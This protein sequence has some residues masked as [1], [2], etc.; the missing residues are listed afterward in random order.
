MDASVLR[1]SVNKPCYRTVIGGAMVSIDHFRK[2]LLAQLARA[3]IGGRIDILINSGE[4]YRL[5]GG[6][7]GSMHG[8]P[9]CCD[10]MQAEMSSEIQ[11]F[12]TEPAER[13][14][15]RTYF[16]YSAR[17]LSRKMVFPA[18]SSATSICHF[19]FDCRSP[20]ISRATSTNSPAASRCA[21]SLS[22]QSVAM[23]GLV[24]SP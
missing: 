12:L 1:F 20:A 18:S 6:Y 2:G 16:R 3:T 22:G 10:A 24:R 5:F 15:R 11:C 19:G 8:M 4:L 17:T 7:P 9:S 23:L 21:A 14:P 13:P